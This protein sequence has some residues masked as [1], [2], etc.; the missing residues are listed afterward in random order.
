MLKKGRRGAGV[1]PVISR[2]LNRCLSRLRP[3][4]G[5]GTWEKGSRDT[6]TKG[7]HTGKEGAEGGGAVFSRSRRGGG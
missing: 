5:P 7:S 1:A 2:G 3:A 6:Q 4:R